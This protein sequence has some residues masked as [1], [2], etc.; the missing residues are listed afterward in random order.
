[1]RDILIPVSDA[2]QAA[3]A[4]DQAIALHRGGPVR[5]HFLAVQRRLP[6]HVSQFL[7]KAELREHYLDAGRRTL[8]PAG[9]RLDDAGIVHEDHVLTGKP[10]ETIVEFAERRHFDAVVLPEAPEGLLSA[11]GLGS[12]AGQVRHLMKHR[13]AASA[14]DGVSATG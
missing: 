8:A 11:L 1:M 6:R 7:G 4:A 12:V 13:I 10:A 14:A 9:R 2:A 3:W 5:I